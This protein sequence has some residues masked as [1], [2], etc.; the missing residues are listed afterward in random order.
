[1]NPTVEATNH[2][3]TASG[4]AVCSTRILLSVSLPC[5]LVTGLQWY[6]H[7]HTN[8]LDSALANMAASPL[9]VP[10]SNPLS[11][12]LK[13]VPSPLRRPPSAIPSSNNGT[14]QPSRPAAQDAQPPMMDL[15]EQMN[16]E[17]RRK[18]VKG[19]FFFWRF[20]TQFLLLKAR[21]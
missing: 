4:K 13:A 19:M 18:Y 6:D 16:L 20:P 1:M 21:P 9:V 7:I 5:L 10:P 11:N 14:P 17:E 2:L 12:A 15:A 8:P 3:A